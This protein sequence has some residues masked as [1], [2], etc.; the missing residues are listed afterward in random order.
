MKVISLNKAQ[1]GMVLAMDVRDTTGKVIFKK[2]TPLDEKVIAVLKKSGIFTIPVKNQKNTITGLQKETQKY[3]V[4]SKEHL[5]LGFKK[6]KSVF[7]VLEDSGNID[8]DTV[9]DIASTIKEDIEKNFSDKLFVPLKKL[10][11]FDEYLYSHSLNV[12]IISTLLGVEAG[13]IGDELLS[14]SISALLHDIGKTKVPIEIMN[15]PRKL[16]QEEMQIMRNHVKFGK[17]LCIQNN[18]KDIGI[19]AGVYEHHERFDGK[20]YL[21]GKTNE[22]ISDFGKLISIADVYDALT[23]TRSYKGPWTPYKTISFILSNVEKQFDGRF[24]QGLINAFGVYPVG[25]RVKLSNGQF[26]TIVASNRSNK[27]RPLIKIDRG[28]TIDLSEEKTIRIVE[29]LDYIYIE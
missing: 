25:T 2:N 3:G 24:A 1:F 8:I 20:G 23:S 5:D 17:E 11:T 14:L 16:T 22:M 7:K 19:V 4:V 6:I 9:V 15:A 28:D 27:I 26:G 12:M 13:I 10:Q 29:V 21:E 18:I